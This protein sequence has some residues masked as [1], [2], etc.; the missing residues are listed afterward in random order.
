MK[1]K[2]KS[3]LVSITFRKETPESIIRLAGEAGLEMIEWGSDVHVK[4]EDTGT[5]ARV[6][7]MTADAG[8]SVAAYG[9]YYRLGERGKPCGAPDE[10]KR[11][12]EAARLLGTDVIRVWGGSKSPADL[13]E[14]ELAGMA[15]EAQIL[16]GYAAGYGLNITLEC[17]NF[18]VTED[19]VSAAS[20]YRRV[21]RDNFLA[22]WQP[23]QFRSF[24]YN[25]GAL[26]ALL[27]LTANI[28]V[29]S[30][31]GHERFPLETGEAQWM[32]YLRTAAEIPGPSG[33]R[34]RGL[35]LEFMH[36]D[37]TGTLRK[38]ASVLKT[39]IEGFENET[40]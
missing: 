10:F 27:P 33:G 18:T 40:I 16:C 7:K 12:C 22:Y 30:W 2:F 19:H 9:S 35:L 8:M 36:D 17:H 24:E 38:A 32:E 5:A 26:K 14:G 39:W 20:F 4:P 37:S 28:H 25:V 34:P 31:K 13:S 21:D 1:E 23:N 11:I 3:G 15:E 6:G 29:F